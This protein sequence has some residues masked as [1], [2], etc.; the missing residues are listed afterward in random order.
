MLFLSRLT[1]MKGSLRTAFSSSSTPHGWAAAFLV[2]AAIHAAHSAALTGGR[3]VEADGWK[4]RITVD[5]LLRDQVCGSFRYE[6]Q[7]CEGDLIYKGETATGFEFRTELRA[8]R[9]LPGCTIQISGDFKRYVE[10]CKDS[11]HEG[12]LTAVAVATPIGAAPAPAPAAATGGAAAP[13][14]AAPPA[15]GMSGQV[16]FRWDNGDVFDGQMLDGKR[17]GKGRMVWASGQTYDGDWRDDIAV[18]EGA[19]AFVNG[20]R[21]QGQVKDGVP[22]G[23]GRMQ[24]ANGD[25]FEGQFERGIPDVEG[26]YTEKDG[27]R[28]TGQWKSGIKHGRG[29]SVWATGQSYEG[30]WVTDKPEGKGSITFANGDR[31]EG[32]VSN[33]LP[34]GKGVKVYASQD[35]YEG[36]FARAKRMGRA[37]IAGR[38]AT[39]TRA[40]GKGAR[41]SAWGATGG[42][43]ATIGKA[44]SPRT[45]EATTAV[46]TSRRPWSLPAAKAQSSPSR[47]KRWPVRATQARAVRERPRPANGRSTARSC[48]PFRWWRRNCAIVRASRAA[49]APPGWSTTC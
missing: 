7:A 29:K 38:T 36:S 12:L 24:F 39:P 6:T 23:R 17:N 47:P 5:C 10:V 30:E 44:S 16:R 40:T 48:S 32:Q 33:G 1:R 45:S 13:P 42:P 37:S 8:G 9:C 41:R 34:Q 18:G 21:Y 46:S 49:T 11:R 27:S 3:F 14:R 35:R 15:K 31:Y 22:Y 20:D 43:A 2:F 4:A 28:Y 26:T 19:M 25:V